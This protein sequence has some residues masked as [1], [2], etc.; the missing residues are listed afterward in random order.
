M[1]LTQHN[2]VYSYS[3]NRLEDLPSEEIERYMQE[4][5]NTY[6]FYAKEILDGYDGQSNAK[7][8]KDAHDAFY[9]WYPVL[10]AAKKREANKELEDEAMWKRACGE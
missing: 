5:Q 1:S 10:N 2:T 4:C 8:F 7:L 9:E 6:R 3:Q